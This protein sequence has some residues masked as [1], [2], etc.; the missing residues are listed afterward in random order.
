[1]C[2]NSQVPLFNEI[3]AETAI[4]Y[5]QVATDHKIWKFEAIVLVLP[6]DSGR[7]YI[8]CDQWGQSSRNQ[9]TTLFIVLAMS[10]A[11]L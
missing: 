8:C 5:C 3:V 7:K 2:K 9:V 11:A 4:L 1:M 6:F 10:S